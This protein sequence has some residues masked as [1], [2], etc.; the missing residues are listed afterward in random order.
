[1]IETA[2]PDAASI[3]VPKSEFEQGFANDVLPNC[4][5]I[6]IAGC[7]LAT[8]VEFDSASAHGSRAKYMYVTDSS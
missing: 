1:M 6:E 3:L 7:D 4:H 5:Q 8:S 2:E